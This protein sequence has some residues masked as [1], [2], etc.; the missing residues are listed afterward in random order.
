MQPSG[1]A[2]LRTAL[3]LFLVAIRGGAFLLEQPQTSL[4]H[5]HPR[6]RWLFRAVGRVTCQALHGSRVDFVYYLKTVLYESIPKFASEVWKVRW[7]MGKYGA[8]TQK[9]H[10]GY[11]NF[12]TVGRLNLGKMTKAQIAAMKKR[13]VSTTKVYTNKAGRKCWCGT[14]HLKKSQL[15]A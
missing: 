13:K 1:I 4:L 3:I 2:R 8:P 15:E 11:A 14:K 6:I 10:V 7:L 5:L 9:P 12:A